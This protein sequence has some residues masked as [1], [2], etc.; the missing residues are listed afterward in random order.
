MLADELGKVSKETTTL[1]ISCL[2]GVV[3][4]LMSDPDVKSNL[5]KTMVSLGSML[6][7]L[8]RDRAKMRVIVV[9]C[10]P[11]NLADYEIHSKFAMV[12]NFK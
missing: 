4:S 3:T 5:E 8:V 7:E 9:H 6:H 11:R 12:M 1:V 10:T 2:S